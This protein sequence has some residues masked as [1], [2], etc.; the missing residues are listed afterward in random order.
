MSTFFMSPDPYFD[1]F[2]KVIDLQKFDLSKH[3]TAGLCLQHLDDCL[4][5]GGMTPSTPGAKIPQWQS[6]LMGAGSS[7]LVTTLS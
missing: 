4:Y 3:R 7:R 1:A 2:N 5:L 6:Q